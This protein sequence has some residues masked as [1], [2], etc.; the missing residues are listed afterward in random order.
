[1]T[2]FTQV[3]TETFK[4]VRCYMCSVPFGITNDIYRR[5]VTD[6]KGSVYCPA[7]GKETCWL[8]SEDQKKIK[9][10][11]RKLE[12][13]ASNAARQRALRDSAEASLAATKGV[14]T[15]LK[16]RVSAGTCPCC[17]RTFKQ[18]ARHM[19]QKHPDFPS[20]EGK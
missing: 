9:E 16:R 17:K 12:W 15:R 7:C 6:A 1:M 13:E 14:V 3:I 18:L 11:Q 10:L 5:V 2:T 4:V 19:K 20:T 8:E